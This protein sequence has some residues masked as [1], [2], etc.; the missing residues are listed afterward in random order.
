M[1]QDRRQSSTLCNIHRRQWKSKHAVGRGSTGSSEGQRTSAT[2][3]F[4]RIEAAT[5]EFKSSD[6]DHLNVSTHDAT[7]AN[8]TSKK[9][10]SA[11][12]NLKIMK[13]IDRHADRNNESLNESA[14]LCLRESTKGQ[15]ADTIHSPY[16]SFHSQRHRDASRLSVELSQN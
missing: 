13:V 10:T 7:S 9:V 4:N 3:T 16:H 14:I 8:V 6:D 5:L 15:R 2:T 11:G 12:S 1:R